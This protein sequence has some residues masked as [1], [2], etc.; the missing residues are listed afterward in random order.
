MV[1][2]GKNRLNKQAEDKKRKAVS[3]LEDCAIM[4]VFVTKSRLENII[5]S[6]AKAFT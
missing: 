1:G 4:D 5:F 6:P 3:F 2:A